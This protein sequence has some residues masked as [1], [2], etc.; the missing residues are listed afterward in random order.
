MKTEEDEDETHGIT[1]AVWAQTF[2]LQAK[3]PKEV[4]ESYELEKQ[5][6]TLLN[7]TEK[8]LATLANDPDRVGLHSTIKGANIALKCR[9]PGRLYTDNMALLMGVFG[10]GKTNKVMNVLIPGQLAAAP[11]RPIVVLAPT[12]AL[13]RKY[14]QELQPPNRAFTIHA[15]LS[16]LDKIKPSLVIIEEAFTLPVAYI[17]FIAAEYKTLLIGDP[18]QI[19]H[20]D[21]SGLWSGC[22]KLNAILPY[23]ATEKMMVTRRCAQD[24]VKIPIIMSV[25]PGITSSSVKEHSIKYVPHGFKNPQAKSICFTQAVKALQRSEGVASSTVH[26]EQG[27]TYP[28]VILRYTG[29]KAERDLIAKSPNHLIVGLTRHTNNLFIQD[30]THTD[31]QSGEL[32]RYMNDANPISFYADNAGLDIQALTQDTNVQ[33]VVATVDEPLV[34]NVPYAAT[35]ADVSIAN[36]VLS[37]YLPAVAPRENQA[38]LFTAIPQGDDAKGTLRLSELGDD[39]AFQSQKHSVYRFDVPQRVMVTKKQYQRMLVKSALSRLGNKTK[40]LNPSATKSLAKRLFKK[41]EVEFDW[42]VSEDLKSTCF[43]EAAE[44]YHGRGH[45]LTQMKDIANWT[46]RGSNS[47][48]SFLKSQQKPTGGKDPLTRDKAGQAIS[49]GIKLSISR[50]APTHGCW[51][52]C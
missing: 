8:A 3:L 9:T 40:N 52:K 36:A 48:K 6:E 11:G 29:S 33:A 39:E 1:H 25:Y 47:V 2:G 13:Q 34:S 23:I 17:N 28:S 42:T 38:N 20:V 49:P 19:E 24:I 5:H 10:S 18:Q 37:R 7:E 46:E 44:K 30:L 22:M 50:S 35:T 21:F 32:V 41:L 43:A 14:E 26:E 27:Q 4:C 45:N 51:R 15:G 12:S 16:K 31:E